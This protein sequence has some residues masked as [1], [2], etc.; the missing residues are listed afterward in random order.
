MG[1][2]PLNRR[3]VFD[4]N[5]VVSALVF[6]GGRLAWLRSAWAM[7]QLVPVVSS[8]TAAELTIVL[9]YPKFALGA[10]D[11]AELLGEYLPYA[12]LFTGTVPGADIRAPDLDDQ[13]FVDL[14][15]AAGAAGLVTGDAELLRLAPRLP[16]LEP[17]ALR[18]RSDAPRA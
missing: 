12:E 7:R 14:C 2:P 4:T 8:A 15:L 9:S 18:S 10:A 6:R 5:V 11:R 17:S 3:Y 1:T 16:V 13:P